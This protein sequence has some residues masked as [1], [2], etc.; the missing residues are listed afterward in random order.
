MESNKDELLEVDAILGRIREKLSERTR[1]EID[2]SSDE[3]DNSDLSDSSESYIYQ[4]D[5]EAKQISKP[6]FLH[7]DNEKSNIHNINI[8]SNNNFN[9]QSIHNNNT[10]PNNHIVIE[11]KEIVPDPFASPVEAR[12][13][14]RQTEMQRIESYK[15][16][17]RYES[18]QN[19]SL[20]IGI[21]INANP[22]PIASN[23]KK[24]PDDN[25]IML[26]PNMEIYET[27]YSNS[28][29]D[30]FNSVKE[31]DN[32]INISLTEQEYNMLVSVLSKRFCKAFSMPYLD[33]K[34][35]KWL[36]DNMKDLLASK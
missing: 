26:T 29:N 19:E 31:Y 9:N 34:V 23:R 27:D 30:I 11:R 1:Y 21:G 25:V 20:P 3:V 6:L 16:S 17:R 24:Y 15:Q 5:F 22:N 7:E 13:L 36:Y 28:E 35:A 10:H 4:Q 2:N 8:S 33:N 18:M 14:I 32:A 12:D